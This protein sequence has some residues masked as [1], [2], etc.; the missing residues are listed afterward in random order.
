MDG[1]QL[2]SFFLPCTDFYCRC[3]RVDR[4]RRRGGDV[5]RDGRRSLSRVGFFRPRDCLSGARKAPDYGSLAEDSWE[6]LFMGVSRRPRNDLSGAWS[7]RGVRVGGLAS[8]PELSVGG[9]GAWWTGLVASVGGGVVAV[10]VSLSDGDAPSS[11]E[12]TVGSNGDAVDWMPPPPG[13]VLRKGTNVRLPSV[14]RYL[15]RR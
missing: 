8:S 4:R 6:I 5:Q 7:V 2:A 12:L 13:I 11:P 3:R 1:G 15:Q 14:A 10:Y 9:E